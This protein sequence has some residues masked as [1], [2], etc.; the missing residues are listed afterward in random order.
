MKKYIFFLL[1][2]TALSL[3][4]TCNEKMPIIDCLSCDDDNDG[5]TILDPQQKRVLVEEFTGVRCIGCPAGSTELKNLQNQSDG[6][7]IPVSIHAGFFAKPYAQNNYDFRTDEGDAILDYL[8]RPEANPAAV[9]DRKLFDGESDLQ[10]VNTSAWAGRI[11][12]QYDQEI[13]DISM[14]MENTYDAANRLLTVQ[15]KGTA[16]TLVNE[17]VRLTIMIT[18]SGVIDHQLT[19]ES[20]PDSDPNYVHNHLLRKVMTPFEGATLAASM[21]E[22]TSFDESFTFTLP[23][24]WEVANCNVIAFTHLTQSSKEVLQAVEEHLAD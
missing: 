16:L 2:F 10:F 24:E 11:A 21:P 15:V 19:P 8:G 20:S 3:L 9:I 5:P 17:E 1:A 14:V 6:R 4:T 7:L 12:Q 13:A 22:G 18:E 23:S